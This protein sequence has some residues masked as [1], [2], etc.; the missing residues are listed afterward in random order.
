[1]ASP[2]CCPSAKCGRWTLNSPP[3]PASVRRQFVWLRGKFALDERLDLS[4]SNL[5]L[6]HLSRSDQK[7]CLSR[8][9]PALNLGCFLALDWPKP[10]N[11]LD[12]FAEFRDR[13]NGL[14]TPAGA[15]LVGAL[16]FFGLDSIGAHREGPR[17]APL[18]CAAGPLRRSERVRTFLNIARATVLA[19]EHL[20]TA[21]LP[22]HRFNARPPPGALYGRGRRHGV[23]WHTNRH[24]HLATLR[25]HWTD[26][27]EDL[28]AE[29]DMLLGCLM[30]APSRPSDGPPFL[31]GTVSHGHG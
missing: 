29:I 6:R 5:V 8:S 17:C 19:L 26:I 20:L 1:M 9:M 11:I 23:E 3:Q 15:G 12:L 24:Q 14:A 27:Q 16:T 7:R 13:T 25:S 28:I 30:G 22:R 4:R 10:A 2:K 18:P 31:F 21:M